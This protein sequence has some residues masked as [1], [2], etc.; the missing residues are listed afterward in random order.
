MSVTQTVVIATAMVGVAPFMGR[1]QNCAL[2]TS[3][4][5]CLTVVYTIASPAPL[6]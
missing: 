4:S 5:A 1:K 3:S 6:A 2:G